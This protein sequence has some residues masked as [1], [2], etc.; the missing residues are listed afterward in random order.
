MS[1]YKNIS[2]VLNETDKQ[3]VKDAL[4]QIRQKLPFL[5]TLTLAERKQAS[6]MGNKNLPFAQNALDAARNNPNIIPPDFSV[7]EYAKDVRL[8]S[9][10]QDIDTVIQQLQSDINDTKLAVGSEAYGA[11]TQIYG[12]VK[13]ASK[14]S[15]GLKPV[16]AQL[17]ARFAKASKGSKGSG[18]TANA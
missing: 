8:W 13:N 1:I 4:A 15:P 17:G 6:K 3:A 9:E 16:A 14:R 7:D 11:A 12:L 10:L 5:I 18:P 2:A